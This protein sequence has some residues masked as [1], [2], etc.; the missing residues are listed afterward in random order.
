MTDQEL[1]D[2]VSRMDPAAIRTAFQ[3]AC[4]DNP[5]VLEEAKR[6]LSESAAKN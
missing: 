6:I 3:A 1:H 4:R 5:A 2:L